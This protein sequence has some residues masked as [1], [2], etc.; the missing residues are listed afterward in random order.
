MA[1]VKEPPEVVQVAQ[2]R[3]KCVYYPGVLSN[4]EL[5][6]LPRTATSV[7]VQ[8]VLMQGRFGTRNTASEGRAGPRRANTPAG[9]W[10]GE[11]RY[12]AS[13]VIGDVRNGFRVGAGGEAERAQGVWERAG[14]SPAKSNTLNCT[15]ST[16]C[17]RRAASLL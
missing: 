7:L 11:L 15:L 3:T 2:V 13:D 17:T 10:A 14:L 12:L 16:V 9:H 8:E 6:Q 4:L 5:R 1:H